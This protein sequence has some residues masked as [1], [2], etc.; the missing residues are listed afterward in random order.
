MATFGL[1]STRNRP[2]R[3]D[4]AAGDPGGGPGREVHPLGGHG[5]QNVNKV[6]TCVYLKHLP[7]GTEVKC[8]QER[9]QALNRFLARR[10]LADK[11]RGRRPRRRA[12]RSGA[13]P[14]SAARSGS[15]RSGPRSRCWPTSAAS[16]RRNRA[17]P[18]A[19]LRATEA[20]S[21]RKERARPARAGRALVRLR[22]LLLLRTR[23][24]R[25]T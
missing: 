5:G 8:Q 22:M 4:G 12:K 13:S 24:A 17:V 18:Q 7:T 9:S 23:T 10:I 16:P 1:D 2:W 3:A 11:D 19:R 14:R 20:R 25:R 21:P 15:A 6:S